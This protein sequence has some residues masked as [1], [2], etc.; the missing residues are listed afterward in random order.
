MSETD[1]VRACL[2]L[3][4]LRGIFAW[5]NNTG[6]MRRGAHVYWVGLKGS[7]DILGLLPDGR[8]LAIECKRPGNRLTPDQRTFQQR[9]IQHHGVAWVVW[10]AAQLEKELEKVDA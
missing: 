6:V 2:Q 8:F 1:L 5:R 9:V 7:S 10:S 3:L 4:A